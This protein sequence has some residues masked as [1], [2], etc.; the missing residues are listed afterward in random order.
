MS[1]RF[2]DPV[3]HIINKLV[4]NEKK[5]VYNLK[6][7]YSLKAIEENDKLKTFKKIIGITN[8]GVEKL[9]SKQI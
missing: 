7:R 3:F 1:F 4:D 2:Y 9:A 6:S 5:T 8:E